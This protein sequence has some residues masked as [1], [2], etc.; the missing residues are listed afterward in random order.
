[1]TKHKKVNA[2]ESRI[3]AWNKAL[4]PDHLNA[5]PAPGKKMDVIPVPIPNPA[6]ASIR[7]KLH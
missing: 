2:Y 6:P 5:V 4:L 1:M 3:L 7:Y